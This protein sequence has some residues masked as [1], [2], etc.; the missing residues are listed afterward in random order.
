MLST[1]CTSCKHLV[2]C[3]TFC[4]FRFPNPKWKWIEKDQKQTNKIQQPTYEDTPHRLDPTGARQRDTGREAQG[5]PPPPLHKTSRARNSSR[6]REG[7]RTTWNGPTSALR[8]DLLKSARDRT[9]GGGGRGH[10]RSMS[11][12]AQ[13]GHAARTRRATRPSSQNAQT[14]WNGVLAGEDKGHPDG[15]TRHTHREGREGGATRGGGTRSGTGPAYSTCRE[16]RANTS[17]ALH[18]AKAVVVH[19]ATHQPRG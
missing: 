5:L 16:R 4:H 15:A 19:S 8:G 2:L 6:K 18:L 9:R 11:A 14:T 13:N 10:C 7:A 1:P 17:R 12:Q 3:E